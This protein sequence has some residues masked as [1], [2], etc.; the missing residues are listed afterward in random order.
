MFLAISCAI[1]G[2]CSIYISSHSSNCE[3]VTIPGTAALA[4][5]T[6]NSTIIKCYCDS[7]LVSSF[8]DST[9]KTVCDPYLTDIYVSQGIQYA[10]IFTSSITNFLFGF[11]VDKLVNCVRPASKSSGMMTKTMIYTIFLILNS[12]FIPVLIYAD[13]FGFQPSNYV[14][15]LTII[16]TSLKDFLQVSNLTLYPDFTQVWYRN[17][18]PIFVNF[19]IV[20]T[21]TVWVFFI[22]DKYLSSKTSLEDD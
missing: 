20:N 7:N 10:V 11:I 21:I 14:S 1:I 3:G 5:A 22:I 8:S 2:L 13:I 18:S 15:F 12:L 9:I 17:V 19:L 6:A 4:N 16:S